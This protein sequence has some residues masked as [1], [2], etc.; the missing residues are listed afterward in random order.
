MATDAQTLITETSCY[1]C[2]SSGQWQLLKLGL[3][4]QI[5]L[6]SLPMA[7]T[8]PAAL[9]E[10]AKCYACLSPGMWQ[11]LE[12]ALLQQIVDGGGGAGSG[13]Q[14]TVGIPVAAPSGN[15]GLAVDENDGTIYLYYGG[16]WH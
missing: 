10:A 9:L 14:C 5:L 4:R 12:L 13:V 2:L 15:C 8:S 1:Q 6:A 16:A 7:D 3:L 11:L